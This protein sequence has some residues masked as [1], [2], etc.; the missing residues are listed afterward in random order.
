M[1]KRRETI[2][3][4]CSII[5][6]YT[7]ALIKLRKGW[8]K[9][10]RI[11]EALHIYGVFFLRF[12]IMAYCSAVTLYQRLRDCIKAG[13]LC[14][15]YAARGPVTKREGVVRDAVQA[16]AACVVTVVT[17]NILSSLHL[18]L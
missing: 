6:C 2:E 12:T 17:V 8:K 13:F 10:R 5:D 9:G 4:G 15:S 14:T 11:N 3:N 7:F 16:G 18:Q 1:V